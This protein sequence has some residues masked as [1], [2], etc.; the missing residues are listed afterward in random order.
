V[1]EGGLSGR[2]LKDIAVER[3]RALRQLVRDRGVVVGC[4]G[5]EDAAS[6]KAL[7]NSGADLVQIYTALVYRGPLLAARISRKLH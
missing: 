1:P 7:L 4:G 5:V 2:P 6:A 3:V